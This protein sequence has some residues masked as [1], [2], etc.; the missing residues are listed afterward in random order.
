MTPAIP[1][2]RFMPEN[3]TRT[4]VVCDRVTHMFQAVGFFRMESCPAQAVLP[5]VGLATEKVIRD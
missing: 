5:L 4:R 1:S 2:K 3:H